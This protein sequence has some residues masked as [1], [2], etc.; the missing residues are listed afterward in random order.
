MRTANPGKPPKPVTWMGDSLAKLKSFPRGAQEEIGFALYQAQV[1]QKHVHAKPMKGF[2]PGMFEIVS[3]VFGDTFRAVYT[4]RLG[5]RIYVLHA[6]Q[7]KA[8]RGIA[9]PRTQINLIKMRLRQA[10]ELHASR[11]E[12]Q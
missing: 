5:E 9:T 4:V 12:K 1:G 10:T 8:K 6:F 7:K 3:D 2:E 11:K